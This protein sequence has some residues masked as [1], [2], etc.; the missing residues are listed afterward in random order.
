MASTLSFTHSLPSQIRPPSDP[1][2]KPDSIRRRRTVFCS[3]SSPNNTWW[4]PLFGWSSDPDYISGKS[5]GEGSK[6]EASE[7]GGPRSR[8][9]LG[10]FTEEKAKELRRKT[11][12]GSAFHDLMY[13][14]A[15]AARLASD[16]SGGVEKR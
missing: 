10:C 2:G 3:S 15:I 11:A 9:A 1:A 7:S 14:S 4:A 6:P 16:V 12:E 5:D 8:F 13:H